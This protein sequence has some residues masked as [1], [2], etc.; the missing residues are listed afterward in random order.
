MPPPLYP[1][2]CIQSLRSHLIPKVLCRS[3]ATSLDILFALYT[4]AAASD[5]RAG[6]ERLMKPFCLPFQFCGPRR[7]A[8]DHLQH[9]YSPAALPSRCIVCESLRAFLEGSFFRRNA[10]KFSMLSRLL[11]LYHAVR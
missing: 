1:C 8:F 6:V 10:R 2:H 4:K 9:P 7:Q 5:A 3:T 11:Q